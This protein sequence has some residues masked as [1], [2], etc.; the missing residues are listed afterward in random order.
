MSPNLA[1]N[2]IFEEQNS[3]QQLDNTVYYVWGEIV[4]LNKKHTIKYYNVN[5]NP[6][7]C[8]FKS[9]LAAKACRNLCKIDDPS[10]SIDNWNLLEIKCVEY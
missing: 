10:I 4:T 9:T 2:L 8:L 3:I 5:G 6:L 7:D 1:Q